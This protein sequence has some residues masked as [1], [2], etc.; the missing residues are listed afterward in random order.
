[1]PWDGGA[2]E[3]TISNFLNFSAFS[4][5]PLNRGREEG[6]ER[7]RG[8]RYIQGEREGGRG[9]E[10]R[11]EGDRERREGGRGKEKDR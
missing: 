5:V 6:R 2:V 4:S 3:L 10:R 1:V 8:E 7:E 11:G 9:R